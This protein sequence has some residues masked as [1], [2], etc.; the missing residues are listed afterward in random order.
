MTHTVED[1]Q[2]T[3]VSILDTQWSLHNVAQHSIN[4]EIVPKTVLLTLFWHLDCFKCQTRR[5]TAFGFNKRGVKDFKWRSRR[6]HLW[7]LSGRESEPCRCV[8]VK[9]RIQ[10]FGA[11]K[12]R[13]KRLA[14]T[15]REAASPQITAKRRRRVKYESANKHQ[16]VDN[17]EC[18]AQTG[19]TWP[20]SESSWETVTLKTGDNSSDLSDQ[21][22]GEKQVNWV[23]VL[24]K[25]LLSSFYY[26]HPVA[27]CGF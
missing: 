25:S 5:F 24:I 16:S 2:S 20:E 11:F 4:T 6:C 3:F 10:T 27:K 26:N 7:R 8:L 13:K 1:V 22:R 15:K 12:R 19:H 23:D 18:R 17:C 21:P 14:S 9:T